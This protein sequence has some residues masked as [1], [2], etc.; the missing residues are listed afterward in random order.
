MNTDSKATPEVTVT[1][2]EEDRATLRHRGITEEQLNEQLRRFKTGFP[3]LRIVEAARLGQG[4]I[5]L[6]KLMK[7]NSVLRWRRYLDEEG[8]VIKFT[9]A[10]GAASRMFKSVHSFVNGDTDQPHH[11][12]DIAELIDNIDKLPFSDALDE[13]CRR[14]YGAGLT[15]MRAEGRNRELLRAMLA[16]EGLNYGQLPKGLLLFHSYPFGPRTPLEEQLVEASKYVKVKGKARVHFTV[17]EEH[18]PLF[19]DF[20]SLHTGPI[21]DLTSTVFDVSLSVQKPST[22]TVAANPDGTPFRD[23]DGKL[24][25]RPGGHGS[26]IENLNDLNASVIFIKNIDNVVPESLAKDTV[27]YKE[28]LGGILIQVRDSIHRFIT[29]LAHGHD[30]PELTAQAVD[31]LRDVLGVEDARFETLKG[32]ELT[33]FV[34]SKLDRPIRV[35]GMVRNEGE[36]GG[37]PYMAYS[38]DGSVAPQILE[39]VQID[40]YNRSYA[41]MVAGATHFN[42]VDLV[43]YVR[44]AN[45]RKYD[46][47]KHVDPDTGFISQKSVNGVP[48]L[49]MERPGLWNGAMSDWNTI[50]VEVP[51][52]TFNP[53]KTVN[54]LLRPTHCT[55]CQHS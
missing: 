19:R 20:L 45:G 11:H 36:P 47:R 4:I 24:V 33:E 16:P 27:T 37:G 28:V 39:S 1:L 34:L 43:C 38:S 3:Y 17:S 48:V 52:T 7:Y 42:P 41:R 49:A 46:L 53:V 44:D 21:Q 50:F 6:D 9:P 54:D 8:D 13:A 30:D 40:P 25:F 51:V 23:K 31:Y 15:Q 29:K 14:L 55:S 12:S 2:T 10:S 18:V 5:G 35:C 32:H 22:D 26:L